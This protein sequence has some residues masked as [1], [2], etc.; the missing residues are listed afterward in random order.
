VHCLVT[1]GAGFIGS[2]LVEHLL[3]CGHQV[4]VIDDLSTGAADNLRAVSSRIDFHQGSI[5]DR[6][7]VERAVAGIECIFH[8]AALPSVA[9]SVDA[10]LDTH[11]VCATGTLEVLEA[12]RHAGVRRV[13]Y[14]SSSSVY[15]NGTGTTRSEADPVCPLSPYAAAKLAGEYYCQCYT[16]IHGLETVRLRFFNVFGPRQ[17][18]DSP[19]SGVIARFTAALLQGQRPTIHGDG[20]QSRDFTYV[21]NV[22]EVLLLAACSPV[23]VG[24][25]Y[26]IGSSG[27]MC[28]LDLLGVLQELLDSALEPCFGP[29]RAGDVRNSRADISR[30]RTE[31]GY[32][33]S[34]SVEEGVRRTL[35]AFRAT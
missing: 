4:R 29:A 13:V 20:L 18:A 22:V 25:V 14:A 16:A 1:G 21:D 30:A 12:A 7:C 5:T 3:A 24:K 8:L 28:V 2:H 34:I 9:R 6:S 26:N 23:A 27:S 15:G 33:P 11:A 10:P 32:T 17:R 35:E 31:L 19:Y